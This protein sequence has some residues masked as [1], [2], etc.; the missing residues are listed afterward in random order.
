MVVLLDLLIV[1]YPVGLQ[2]A[3]W[4]AGSVGLQQLPNFLGIGL[5]RGAVYLQAGFFGVGSFNTCPADQA[6]GLYRMS[7]CEVCV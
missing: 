6:R 2:D 5:V 1:V 3:G 4:A 7:C